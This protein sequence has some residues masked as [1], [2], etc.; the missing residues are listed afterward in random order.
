MSQLIAKNVDFVV[1]ECD[2]LAENVN[3]SDAVV[4]LQFFEM[5]FQRPVQLYYCVS[6][7]HRQFLNRWKIPQTEN[8]AIFIH[9]RSELTS[10]TCAQKREVQ[11]HV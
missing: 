10:N 2:N 9:G 1:S 7:R 3:R 5:V 6:V 11:S 4:F 8:Q